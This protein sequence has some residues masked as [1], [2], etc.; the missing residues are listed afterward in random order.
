M[1]S[2][3]I[4]TRV[5]DVPRDHATAVFYNLSTRLTSFAQHPIEGQ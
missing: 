1:S 3:P 5:Q 4:I 2:T